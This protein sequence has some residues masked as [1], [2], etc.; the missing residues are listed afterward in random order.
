M[1]VM[2]SIDI[3]LGMI[4]VYLTFSLGVSALNEALAAYFSSRARWLRKGVAALLTPTAVAQLDPAAE[5]AKAQRMSKLVNQVMP[6]ATAKAAEPIDTD[7]FYNSPF[8]SALGLAKGVQPRFAPSYIAPWTMLQ[9]LLDSA[10]DCKA[11]TLDSVAAVRQAVARLPEGTPARAAIEDLLARAGDNMEHLRKLVDEWFGH[12]DEQVRS[13][14]RQKTQR[15]LVGLSVVVAVGVNLDTI[16]LFK[17]LSTDSKTR[18]ALVSQALETASQSDV[19]FL[20]DGRA[21]RA[22]QTQLDHVQAEQSKLTTLEAAASA[23]AKALNQAREAV[24]LERAKFE[25]ATADRMAGLTADGLRFGWSELDTA[26]RQKHP[27]FWWIY[28]ALGLI[29][30]AAALSMGAPFW[31]DLLKKVAT[32]RSTGLDLAERAAKKPK[33]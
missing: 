28:K 21:L 7:R 17:Q 5:P 23:P 15:V 11:E 31:F 27:G 9:G 2:K 13:W 6:A 32:V 16:E 25:Q 30:S 29:L 8:I 1:G 26:A 20:L 18:I 33:A 10:N 24:V 3:A 22:A 4:V 19:N 14:Y 12:F